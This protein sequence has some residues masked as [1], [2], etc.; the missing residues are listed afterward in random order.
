MG[1]L[2]EGHNMPTDFDW[3]KLDEYAQFLHEQD[4]LRQKAGVVDLQKKLRLD[5]DKQVA[6][7]RMKKQKQREEEQKYYLNQLVG[8]EQWK[9]VE[10]QKAEEIK[11]KA[12]KEKRDRDEQ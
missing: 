9:Q 3:S 12:Q 6:D 2:E 1:I 5:L 11:V 10:R 7:A 8:I 4:A